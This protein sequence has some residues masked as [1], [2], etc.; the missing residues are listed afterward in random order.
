LGSWTYNDWKFQ[1]PSVIIILIIGIEFEL[2]TLFPK[3]NLIDI[4]YFIISTLVIVLFIHWW[5]PMEPV[6]GPGLETYLPIILGALVL[7]YIL[8]DG[9]KYGVQKKNLRVK[10]LSE[11][12]PENNINQIGK[13]WL[14]LWDAAEKFEKFFNFKFNLI[15]WVIATL[16]SLLILNGFSL[17]SIF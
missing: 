10:G 2:L 14:N 13:N 3:G 9:I 1:L 17:F 15:C 6:M 4:L 7:A 8:K 5:V 11:N 12:I 16:Q